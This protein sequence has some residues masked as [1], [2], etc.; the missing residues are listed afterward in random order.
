MY[1]LKKLWHMDNNFKNIDDYYKT[2]LENLTSET[3]RN[4]WKEM[5][6]ALFWLRYRWI[7]GLGSIIILCGLGGLIYTGQSGTNNNTNTQYAQIVNSEIPSII[8]TSKN[9]EIVTVGKNDIN[10]SKL[11][12]QTNFEQKPNIINQVVISSNSGINISSAKTN[13]KFDQAYKAEN[14]ID[15]SNKVS[16]TLFTDKSDLTT[17]DTKKII[18][19]ISI[20][21]DTTFGHN[22]LIVNKFSNIMDE[23]FSLVVYAGPAYSLMDVYGY[24]AEYLAYRNANESNQSGWSIGSEF[25]LKIKNW[26]ITTGLSYSVYNQHRSYKHSYQEYSPNDSY[27]DYDTTWMWFIDPPEIGIPIVAGI[28]SSWVNVYKDITI[29]NSGI[30]QVSYFEIPLLV[31]Y[32]YNANMFSF[33]INTGAYFGFLV[34]S[35]IKVPDFENNSQLVETKVT[36]STMVNFAIGSSVYYHLS[37]NTSIY[38]SPYYKQNLVSVFKDNYP[39]NQ[40]FKTYGINFGIS[41]SF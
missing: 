39:V 28:D 5:R 36:R 32:R 18:S 34:N 19:N 27:F 16:N 3:D 11:D 26:I 23:R 21:P 24:N 41:Y 20:N 9:P 14:E 8:P 7:I 25:K 40:R 13:I 33:E 29:D 38:I 4:I 1:P 22:R 37:R 30:N 17:I 35:N 12:E 6:W 10:E 31:G 2:N 15:Y